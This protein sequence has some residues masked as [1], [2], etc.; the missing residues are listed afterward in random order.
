MKGVNEGRRVLVEGE[1]GE[2]EEVEEGGS[3]WPLF[4]FEH[5]STTPK[6]EEKSSGSRSRG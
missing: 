3:S 2:E 6:R 4:G 5:P 1:E